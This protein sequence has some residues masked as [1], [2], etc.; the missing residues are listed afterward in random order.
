VV[1]I[2]TD[3]T[4]ELS[5]DT[6]SGV[7]VR[8]VPLRVLMGSRVYRDW[9][10]IGPEDVYRHM[11]EDRGAAPPTTSPPDPEDFVAVFEQY[12]SV[13]DA[14]VSLHISEGLS[15][16]VRRARDAARALGAEDRIRVV[17]SRMGTAPLGELVLHAA[18]LARSGMG[19]EAIERE[20]LAMRDAFT[21]RFTVKD[22]EYLRRGG[23]LSR[24]RE[25]IGNLLGVRPVL[26]FE[27]GRIVPSRMSR[28]RSAL[29]SM[30][31]DLEEDF[32]PRPVKIVIAY[33]GRDRDGIEEVRGAIRAS[34]LKVR[35]GRVYQIGPV[36]GAH[37]GPGAVGI[38]AY[39]A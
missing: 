5:A 35:R 36:I 24:A 39:P 9:H 27:N 37:V 4:C 20:V 7:G 2:V 22:L 1:G 13:Y 26:T 21:V 30:V 8:A 33:G 12:L 10:D 17:D 29:S 32:G 25:V 6:L 19:P 14:V 16:T 38:A 34:A 3:S 18:D 28:A 31:S 11:T 15:E 23:R